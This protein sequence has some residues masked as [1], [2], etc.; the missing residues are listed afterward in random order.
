M[1]LINDLK[2]AHVHPYKK[3]DFRLAKLLRN[4]PATDRKG[5]YAKDSTIQFAPMGIYVVEGS[6]LCGWLKEKIVEGKDY[7]F[8]V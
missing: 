6:Y 3:N 8:I 7:K 5:F 1:N 2:N 4:I